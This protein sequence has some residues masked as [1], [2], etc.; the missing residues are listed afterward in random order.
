MY[1]WHMN[2]VE[3]KKIAWGIKNK[4][5]FLSEEH[6]RRYMTNEPVKSFDEELKDLYRKAGRREGVL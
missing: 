3:R 4:D 5:K 6:F 2:D 1:E